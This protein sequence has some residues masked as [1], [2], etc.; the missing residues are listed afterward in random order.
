MHS[1]P[2]SLTNVLV[3][4]AQY[5]CNAKYKPGDQCRAAYGDC[6]LPAVYD[7]YC[8]CPD[9]GLRDSKYVRPN[10]RLRRSPPRSFADSLLAALP[11][12][13]ARQLSV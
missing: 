5:K 2:F 4:C 11:C 1:A 9:N 13:T 7:R 8:K 6:D 10:L 3:A 12:R